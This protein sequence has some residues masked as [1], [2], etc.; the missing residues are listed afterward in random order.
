MRIFKNILKSEKSKDLEIVSNPKVIFDKEIS[1][2]Q[3]TLS[4]HRIGDSVN[5]L[6]IASIDMT[7]LE[8]YPEKTESRV[9]KDGKSYV[10]IDGKE[11]EF[12][13]SERIKAVVMSGG[14]LGYKDGSRFRIKDQIIDSF[15]LH[16]DRLSA[17]TG[18]SKT[19]LIKE[20]GKNVETRE[21]YEEY[22]GTLFNTDILNFERQISITWDD[23][24]NEI[25][26]ICIGDLVKEK[27]DN[28]T[29]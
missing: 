11:I 28:N 26:V 2:S 16:Q 21:T 18:L 10:I 20:L 19:K 7:G 27:V 9:W 22:D 25:S 6:N 8:T 12:T 5:N 15:S 23:W 13:L 3:L 4:G 24:D 17:Y 1:V 29:V 14:W